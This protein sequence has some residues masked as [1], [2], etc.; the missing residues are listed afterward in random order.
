M[1]LTWYGDQ[2]LA[3]LEQDF[4]EAAELL[5]TRIRESITDTIWAWPDGESPRDIVAK[6]QLRDSQQPMVLEAPMVAVYRN[7]AEHALAVHEG[8]TLKNGFTGPARSWMTFTLEQFD[9]PA[10]LATISRGRA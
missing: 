2:I 3:N 4:Q 5:D 9:F 7:T 8:Y 6:G 1:E 10:V